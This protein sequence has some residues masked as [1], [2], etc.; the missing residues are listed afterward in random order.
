MASSGGFIWLKKLLLDHFQELPLK[1]KK[2]DSFG[3]GRHL[4]LR[5]IGLLI[6]CRIH[7]MLR[8]QLDAEIADGLQNRD[9]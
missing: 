9:D 8:H 5:L 7:P 1:L 6:V 4:N 2:V 3:Q